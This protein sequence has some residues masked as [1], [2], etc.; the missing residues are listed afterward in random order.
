MGELADI[1]GGG[2]PSSNISK[3]WNGD[4]DW[5]TPAEIGDQIYL[6]C[7]RRK[8]SDLG[9]KKSSAKILPV[10][11]ILFTSRASI[12]NTAI[13][14]KKGCTNQGFESIV[15]KKNLLDCYFIFSRT[16]ELKKY[17]EMMGSGS[18]FLEI[19]GKQVSN[20]LMTFPTIFEQKKIGN[21]FKTLDHLITL[22]QRKEVF[23]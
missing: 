23:Y 22:H 15:P 4:I 3:Y 18:T 6:N 12:G 7:S 21:I 11:T 5:Y 19:S 16:L 9:L 8:I 13:L 2:T 10:G 1:Y 20:M 17:G 14:Q